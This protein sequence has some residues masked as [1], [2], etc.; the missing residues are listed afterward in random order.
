[1]QE[2][3]RRI[4]KKDFAG[5]CC[6]FSELC[7]VAF[8]GIFKSI[9][10]LFVQLRRGLENKEIEGEGEG[11]KEEEERREGE[12]EGGRESGWLGG[13]KRGRGCVSES[14]R[15]TKREELE[16]ERI[17]EGGREREIGKHTRPFQF[18]NISYTLL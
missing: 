11:W 14:E 7:H 10:Y 13:R 6:E 3:Y 18:R 4:L 15:E 2:T 17:K 12:K 16:R 8:A 5:L 9:N 1:M